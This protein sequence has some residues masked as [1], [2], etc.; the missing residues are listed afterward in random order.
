M[1]TPR[2]WA[3]LGA[4]IALGVLWFL[5][6][7][8]E[9]GLAAVLLVAAAVSALAYVIGRPPPV[10][11]RRRTAPAHVHDGD[12][13][14]VTLSLRNSGRPIRH[15]TITDHVTGLGTAEFAA[16]SLGSNAE[17]T[18]SYRVLCRPRGVYEVGPARLRMAD[19]LGLA[20]R[21]I[22]GGRTDLLVVYPAVEDLQGLPGIPGRNL[23]VNAPR[24]EQ[25]QRGGEDF[26]TL[27]EYQ[28]GDD[29]RR[30][31]WP[32]SA[33]RDQLM[34][35]QL[36]T[37][38]QTKA[39]VV[40]DTRS[41]SYPDAAD[42]ERAVSGAASIVRHLI[43]NGLSTELWAGDSP[44]GGSRNDYEVTMERLAG[45]S[46]QPA[47]DLAILAPALRRRGGGG[48]LVMVTGRADHD[49]LGL[50]LSLAPSYPTAV[51]M[52]AGGDPSAAI[53]HGHVVRVTPAAAEPWAPAWTR[54]MRSTWHAASVGS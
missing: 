3:V 10:A 43:H 8:A 37:P 15:L 32:S 12:H 11:V 27:R 14:S 47:A 49:L 45:V 9:M 26:Y 50:A 22:S 46:T 20:S 4:G 54:A 24:P 33:R 18:A 35:R 25:N 41:G 38:W 19:P 34:I 48:L 28:Q 23:A 1:F 7:E 6:G 51:L 16:A 30:V 40:L 31:H 39:L 21:E 13:A 44:R 29:L 5:F 42:F 52:D 53:G 17:V 2:G 36:E